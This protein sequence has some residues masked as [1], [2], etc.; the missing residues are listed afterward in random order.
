MEPSLLLLVVLAF[1]VGGISKGA[2]G[3]GLPTIS[4]AILTTATELRVA[5][6]I[7]MFP[8]FAANIWQMT[9]GGMVGG[10]LRRFGMLNAFACAGIWLGTEILYTAAPSGL[11]LLLATVVIGYALVELFSVS[12]TLPPR[13]EKPLAP[14]VGFGAG[15]VTGMT[16]TMLWF[17][18]IYLQALRLDKDTFIKA[19]GLSLLI[20]TVAWAI[21]LLSQGAMTLPV[22]LASAIAVPPVLAGMAIG[23]W[24]RDRIPQRRFRCMIAVLLLLLG[25]NLLRSVLL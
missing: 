5:V 11:N 15:L 1:F 7:L 16:G 14:L 19:L 13:W 24:C 18:M 10:L 12:F 23:H 22:T 8:S 25:L 17:V 21:S 3:M 4:V 9:R 6:P 20:G 2:T